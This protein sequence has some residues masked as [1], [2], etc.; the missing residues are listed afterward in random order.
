MSFEEWLTGQSTMKHN[1]TDID[2]IIK[3]LNERKI[4][5]EGKFLLWIK[6]C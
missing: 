2:S 3:N 6:S 4:L 5:K 1:Q